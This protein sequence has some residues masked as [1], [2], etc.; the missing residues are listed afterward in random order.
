MNFFHVDGVVSLLFTITM[1]QTINL[2]QWSSFLLF[3]KQVEREQNAKPKRARIKSVRPIFN[4][5]RYN[6][7]KQEL[8]KNRIQQKFK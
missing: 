3:K 8:N 6:Q 4:Y 7:L 2:D 5:R 1:E